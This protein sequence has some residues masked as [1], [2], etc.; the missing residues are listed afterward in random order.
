MKNLLLILLLFYSLSA[1]ISGWDTTGL[2][3]SISAPHLYFGD[4]NNVQNSGTTPV[5]QG[6]SAT[7][8]R[9][10]TL[11]NML[12][13]YGFLGGHYSFDGTN[14]HIVVNDT[15]TF[16]NTNDLS[17]EFWLEFNTRADWDRLF[18]QY[19]DASSYMYIYTDG[20]NNLRVR[21]E[22]GGT[23]RTIESSDTIP[24]GLL[25]LVVV[26]DADVTSMYFNGSEVSGYATQHTYI[27]GNVTMPNNR[28]G[29]NYDGANAITWPLYFAAVY[30]K[31]L[32]PSNISD[33]YN[34][35]KTF[36]AL[37]GKDN[38]DGTMGFYPLSSDT[39]NG[40][41]LR[42]AS[43][44]LPFGS[45]YKY[46]SQDSGNFTAW[47]FGDG[48]ECVL[49]NTSSDATKGF[50]FS[51][52]ESYFQC[53]NTSPAYIKVN[54]KAILNNE[55][56]HTFAISFRSFDATGAKGV[57]SNTAGA[58]AYMYCYQ[59]NQLVSFSI[60]GNSVTN[61]TNTT[62]Q[63]PTTEKDVTLYIC[64]WGSAMRLFLYDGVLD[65]EM[66]YSPADNY[67]VGTINLTS[68]DFLVG[69]LDNASS[70]YPM[71]DNRI[72]W[73]MVFDDTLTTTEMEAYHGL[74]KNLNLWAVD[75]GD[76]TFSLSGEPSGSNY[77]EPKYFKWLSKTWMGWTRRVLEKR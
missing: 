11:T 30:D 58:G 23:I 19:T 29:Q 47:E 38:G 25:H 40:T 48:G 54:R 8:T 57:F 35:G 2:R 53:D 15:I 52:R 13:G 62:N 68:A 34:A 33:K 50:V 22:D 56:V 63:M 76:T 5:Y 24:Y 32:T 26:K 36:N 31:A 64:K 66:T 74:G 17:F 41:D 44:V 59:S 45:A 3:Y 9:T 7:S 61:T 14:D 77:C 21:Y 43:Y 18:T 71:E 60:S 55:S 28:I 51:D 10:A 37:R 72:Y 12:S 46:S 20:D 67:D 42:F 75:N 39:I 1:D 65:G 73:F 27:L 6:N 70:I 4:I 49:V 16:T 69:A